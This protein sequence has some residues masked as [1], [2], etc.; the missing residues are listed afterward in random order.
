MLCC[1]F[2][3]VCLGIQ[4]K[5]FSLLCA[6]IVL[7]QQPISAATMLNYKLWYHIAIHWSAILSA[8]HSQPNQARNILNTAALS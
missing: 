8:T 2:T 5:N 6:R 3:L 1:F 4:S 7:K